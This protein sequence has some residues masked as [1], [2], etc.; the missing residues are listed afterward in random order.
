M[1]KNKIISKNHITR[2]TNKRYVII[3]NSHKII[4]KNKYKIKIIKNSNNLIH[5]N[6]IDKISIEKHR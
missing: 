3:K 4:S 6:I 2:I 1:T 5:V